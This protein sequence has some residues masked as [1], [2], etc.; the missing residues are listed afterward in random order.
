ML[1]HI[2]PYFDDIDIDNISESD[3]ANYIKEELDHGNRLNHFPLCQNSVRRNLSIIKDI[4]NFA[5][6][7]Q[8][9]DS[10]QNPM[11]FIPT[12]KKVY[13]K[14]IE[15][16][17]HDE[18]EKIIPIARPKWMG[19]IILI[20]YLTGM[21]RS[22]I[23][24]LKWDDIN[25][26]EKY[27]TVNRGV[28]TYAPNTKFVNQPKSKKSHRVIKLDDRSL[29]ML[30]RRYDKRTSNE[31]VFANKYGELICPW[32]NTKYFATACKSTGITGKRFHDLRH[33]HITELV[34]AGIPLP[35]IQ[36]RAGHSNINTTMGYTH[37]K[38]E[39]Q[40]QVIDFLNAR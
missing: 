39:M 26:T 13:T 25:F 12:L 19:D 30:Y 17:T 5:V 34:K 28:T 6:K 40:Q 32:Y 37:I 38:P 4:F 8:I 18:V 23:Y 20:A 14:E 31:W 36:Q 16:F 10:S 21:R 35:I 3:I 15:I 24:G 1:N 27:L 9:I 22:E 11:L 2:A 29:D 33:T 7:K